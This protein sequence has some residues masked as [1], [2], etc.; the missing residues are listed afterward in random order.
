MVIGFSRLEVLSEGVERHHVPT[1][2]TSGLASNNQAE[3]EPAAWQGRYAKTGGGCREEAAYAAGTRWRLPM[4]VTVFARRMFWKDVL[5]GAGLGLATQALLVVTL[6]TVSILSI[7][8][9]PIDCKATEAK[10]EAAICKSADLRAM[11]GEVDR[12]Y[13]AA[14]VRWTASMS[15]SV[16]AM[17]EDWLKKRRECGADEKCLMNRMVEQIKALDAMRPKSPTWILEDK[18]RAE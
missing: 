17:Q 7:Q 11:D 3:T 12:A 14:R 2:S 18:K 8:A 15:N 13:R 9:D 10:D 16:K 5:V 1:L 6:L 4:V